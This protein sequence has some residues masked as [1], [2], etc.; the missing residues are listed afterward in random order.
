[1]TLSSIF[2]ITDQKAK[3]WAWKWSILT[4]FPPGSKD[5]PSQSRIFPLTQTNRVLMS[6]PLNSGTRL[7]LAVSGGSQ[8]K[9]SARQNLRDRQ[10][11]WDLILNPSVGLESTC[12]CMGATPARRVQDITLCHAAESWAPAPP[13]PGQL[14]QK[15]TSSDSACSTSYLSPLSCEV[16]NVPKTQTSKPKFSP[17][18][19]DQE[20]PNLTHQHVMLWLG[21]HAQAKWQQ[22][23]NLGQIF[24]RHPISCWK[25]WGRVDSLTSG[26]RGAPPGAGSCMIS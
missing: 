26:R 16:L 17:A 3:K 18:D 11:I 22:G 2:S 15:P 9:K 19:L 5:L 23:L 8:K 21:L 7:L 14:H 6:L 13:S 20:S 25:A 4:Q 10:G 12:L 1:M 24:P